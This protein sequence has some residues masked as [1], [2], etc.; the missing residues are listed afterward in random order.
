MPGLTSQPRKI[1]VNLFSTQGTI[2]QDDFYRGEDLVAELPNNV[3]A[4]LRERPAPVLRYA[5]KHL[6]FR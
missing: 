6:L 5:S 4:I 3:N 1:D 2:G